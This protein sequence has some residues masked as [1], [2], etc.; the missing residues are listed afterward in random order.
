MSAERRTMFEVGDK[1][2]RNYDPKYRSGVP[3]IGTVV[4]ITAKRGDVVVDYGAYKETYM[5]NGWQRGGG[6]WNCS[7][8]TK[9]TQDIE[10]EIRQLTLIRTCRTEFE[11]TELTANQAERILAIL[12]EDME[13]ETT[14]HGNVKQDGKE[15][16]NGN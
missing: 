15:N 6:V 5:S 1:V 16:V 3:I 12:R 4:K 7:M 2:I 11:K 14:N 13:R 8:I 9:L 10:E